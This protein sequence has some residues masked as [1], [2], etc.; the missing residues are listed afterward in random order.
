MINMKRCKEKEKKKF[1]PR[2]KYCDKQRGKKDMLYDKS[3]LS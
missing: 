3:T 1:M 2:L